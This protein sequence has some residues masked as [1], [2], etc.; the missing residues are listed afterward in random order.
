MLRGNLEQ[1]ILASKSLANVEQR[2]KDF[3]QAH[4]SPQMIYVTLDR[5]SVMV[6]AKDADL[7]MRRAIGELLD[8][9]IAILRDKLKEYGVTDV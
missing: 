8:A 2:N 7:V 3:D 6:N 1:A 9:E 5:V 4:V